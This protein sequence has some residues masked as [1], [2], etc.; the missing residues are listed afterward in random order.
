M[1]THKHILTH[2]HTH[3]R[4]KKE[5]I[6]GCT[7]AGQTVPFPLTRSS[8]HPEN[9]KKIHVE[10]TT[11]HIDDSTVAITKVRDDGSR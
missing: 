4:E 7:A 2:I 6:P 1:Y 10:S 9:Q 8:P 11:V 5:E 3:T